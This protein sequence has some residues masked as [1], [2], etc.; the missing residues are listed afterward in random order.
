MTDVDVQDTLGLRPVGGWAGAGGRFDLLSETGWLR[1]SGTTL[2]ESKPPLCCRRAS[3]CRWSIDFYVV[4]GPLDRDVLNVER[5]DRIQVDDGGVPGTSF[6][7]PPDLPSYWYIP[8]M[9]QSLA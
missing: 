4:E 5:P 9:G 6:I 1:L 8:S 7:A 2:V 3:Q